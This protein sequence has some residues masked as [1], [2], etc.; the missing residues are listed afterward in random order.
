MLK[1]IS[2]EE[3]K[4]GMFIHKLEGSWFSHPF[5]KRRFLLDDPDMLDALRESAV[6][7]VIID[8]A[9]GM[10]P[11]AD[12]AQG[13]PPAAALRPAASPPHLSVVPPVPHQGFAQG[14]FAQS[15]FARPRAA[16]PIAREFGR[17]KR[18]AGEAL[19]MVSR[20][21]IEVRL[22]KAIKV[23]DVEPVLDAVYASV[24][25]NLYAFNGLLRC[26]ND[27]E[28]VYRHSLAVSAL[29]I[30]LARQMKL[31]PLEIRDAGMAGLLM[32]VGVGQLP[33]DLK[34]VG[35]DYTLL[36]DDL[37]QQ[38]VLLGYTFL[39][40]AGDIP[41]AVLR[42]VLHHHERLDGGGFP[43][44]LT[45]P[46]IEPLGRMAAICDTYDTLIAAGEERVRLDPA[47]AIRTLRAQPDKFDAGI[48]ERF[49][50]A[51]GVYPI[52]SFVRLRSGRLAMVVDE[53]PA[54]TALPTVRTF[55]SLVQGRKVRGETIALAHCYGEDAIE[56]V[57]DLS[58][59]D[60]PEIDKLRSALLAA[61]CREAQ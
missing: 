57:A 9:R 32:D 23:H 50:E 18:A 49:V 48:L 44:G 43:Q 47:E 5:W 3:I 20:T 25:R 15:A 39:K 30:A 21:F 10:V 33:V 11:E 41:D 13:V 28:P 52:G 4:L 45:A 56:G 40:A 60:L 2:T 14:A 27:S 35:G 12:K 42:A 54:E 29:M 37:K 22:G 53:D 61:A 38:H 16:L 24:Q 55:W 17:A 46:V 31:S 36:R 51:V 1:R 7:A 6:P 59:L 58:G 19:K 34:S 26:Q 8:T